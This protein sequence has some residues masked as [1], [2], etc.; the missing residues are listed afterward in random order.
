MRL[1]HLIAVHYLFGKRSVVTVISWISLIGLMVSTAALIIVLSVYNG[2]GDLTK[3]LFGTFDPELIIEPERGKTFR[4]RDLDLAALQHT[5]G[6][7]EVAAIAEETAW[8]TYGSNQAIVR[9]RGVDSGYCRV[10]GFDTLVT[11]NDEAVSLGNEADTMTPPLYVGGEIYY[12]LAMHPHSN[13]PAAVHIPK[14]GSTSLGLSMEQAFNSGYALPSGYFFIQQDID[15]Q[16]VVTDIAFVRRL[17]GYAPDEVTALAVRLQ[18]GASVQRVK[19]RVET[20]LVGSTAAC[21]VKDRYDQQPLYYKIFRSERLGIY[22]ILSLIVLIST[23][24]LV[25]SLSLLIINKR[26]DIFILQSMG[27]TERRLRRTFRAEGMLICAVAVVAGLAAGFLVCWM[28]QHFGIVRMGDGN[29]VV[30]AF[31]VAMRGVDFAAT[32][33]LV[34][35]IS[36]LSVTFTVQRAKI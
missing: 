35:A 26:R 21:T 30:D 17:M 20:T 33:L 2:I 10:T 24:S 25:A 36:T 15:R 18:P 8:L 11:G 5:A 29:F 19:H 23:F 16:Y 13:M 14:R 12:T 7:A 34:M 27:M 6:V 1:E 3:S 32:F 31:P 9:L 22:L 28:Q 4:T